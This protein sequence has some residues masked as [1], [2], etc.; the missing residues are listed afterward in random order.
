M[1]R[2][3]IGH[4]IVNIRRQIRYIIYIISVK[5]PRV[6]RMVEPELV[7]DGSAEAAAGAGGQVQFLRTES[8]IQEGTVVLYMMIWI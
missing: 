4:S 2:I 7:A 6:S 3:R 8:N 5:A 1:L